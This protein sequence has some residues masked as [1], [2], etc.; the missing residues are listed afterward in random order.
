MLVSCRQA[1]ASSA[2]KGTFT[3]H[4]ENDAIGFEDVDSHYTNGIQFSYQT[5]ENRVWSWLDGWARRHF[6][7]DPETRL[8]GGVAAGQNLYTPADIKTT[9]LVPD[10]RPYA[11]W[12]HFD[13]SLVGI[14]DDVLR[15]MEFSFGWIGPAAGGEPVQKWFHQ[16]IGSPE[17]MGWDNQLN[18]ELTIMA[19]LEQKWR[20]I[21]RTGLLGLEV[22]LSPHG[23]VALGNV[24]TYGGL[25]G[26]FRLGHH[27]A[28]DFGP[29][30]I[31]PAPPG[32][33][34]VVDS[35][36]FGWYVFAGVD[37]RLVLRNI[38]L[39]GN[40]FSDSHRVD[41]EPLVG[42]LVTGFAVSG[43]G[44]RL[45]LVYVNRSPE[46]KGQHSADH[47]GS[48]TFSVRF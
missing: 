31:Q 32:S 12:L 14:S 42:D 2:D 11:A 30:R 18:N 9:E 22:D 28:R 20:H 45:G 21:R 38:L 40:T 4:F 26:T 6:Y 25:G 41:K 44:M 5:G 36:G 47:F 27:L 16:I 1:C 23:S 33:G 46:F 10:D 17:P 34:H 35:D 24:F 19:V 39:D 8:R 13:L 29:P 7:R 48:F 15:T 43:L 37:G 3:L